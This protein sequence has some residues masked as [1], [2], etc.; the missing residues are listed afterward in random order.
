ML[1]LQLKI[2][3]R[4]LRIKHVRAACTLQLRVLGDI[5]TYPVDVF[6]HTACHISPALIYILASS[7]GYLSLR[8][9]I[10]PTSP[11]QSG[12]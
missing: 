12:S 8:V 2:A 1:Q 4:E 6:Q 11:L 5:N 3:D 7:I 10:D 9:L